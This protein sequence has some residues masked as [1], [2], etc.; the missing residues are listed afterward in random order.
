MNLSKIFEQLIAKEN[1]SP[2]TMQL[3]MQACM[4]G[5]LTDAQNAAFLA[6]MRAK[7]ETAEELTVAV[8]VMMNCAYRI[9]LGDNLIDIVGTG[10]DGK[11]TFNISTLSS[12]I[13]AAAGAPVAKH[14]NYSVSSRSGSAD[15]LKE[16]NIQLTLNEEQLKQCLQQTKV[17]FLF[18]PYFHKALQHVRRARQ[19]LGIRTFFNLLGPLVNPAQVKKHVVGVFNKHWQEPL[20]KVLANT[21][22]E[23]ALIISSQDGMDEVSIATTTDVLELY[24][25]KLNSWQIDPRALGCFHSSLDKICVNSPKESLR[26]ILTVLQGERGPARDIALLNSA[27]AIYC[28]NLRN[29]LEEAIVLAANT[30][31]SGQALHCFNQLI[32]FSQNLEPYA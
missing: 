3:I 20:A 26:I 1:L 30:I 14:G 24:Q 27:T 23:R 32:S 21:G 22:S 17:C 9:D 6:L 28:A 8:K 29:N 4:N 7:G 2:D 12:I 31:D 16:A 19:E 11:N 10:G 5:E 13:T 25:G 15:L 18:A